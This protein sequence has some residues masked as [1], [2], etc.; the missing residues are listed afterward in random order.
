MDLRVHIA[1]DAAPPAWF[2]YDGA[3][4]PYTVND[5]AS[6]GYEL[7]M[8]PQLGSDVAFAK[9]AI[10]GSNLCDFWCE[11]CAWPPGQPRL[12]DQFVTFVQGAMTATAST[13]LVVVWAQGGGDSGDQACAD[14]YGTNLTALVASWRPAWGVP[15]S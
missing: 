11:S 1:G 12:A 9:M 10:G 13:R 15:G 7:S 4:A 2:D 6:F 5:V 14:A 8:G 3:L